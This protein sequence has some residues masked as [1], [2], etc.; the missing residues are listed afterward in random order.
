MNWCACLH[1]QLSPTVVADSISSLFPIA[2]DP[3]HLR[4]D[5]CRERSVTKQNGRSQH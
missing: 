5:G 1:M 2:T 4:Q 3:C